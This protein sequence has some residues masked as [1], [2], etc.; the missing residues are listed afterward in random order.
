VANFWEI[1][2][3][4]GDDPG[5]GTDGAWLDRRKNWRNHFPAVPEPG[6]KCRLMGHWQELS[7]FERIGGQN[8]QQVFW[9]TL[10]DQ[11]KVGAH[12]LRAGE[13]LCAIALIKRLFPRL[14]NIEAVIGWRPGGKD[15]NVVHWPSTSYVAALPWLKELADEKHATARASYA[16]AASNNLEAGHMGETETRLYGFPDGSLFDLDGHLLHE[17]GLRAWLGEGLKNEQARGAMLAA[18]KE[19]HKATDTPPAREFYALLLMDGDRIGEQLQR[20]GDT[21][22][23]GLAAFTNRVGDYFSPGNDAMGALVYAGGDDVL[24]MLPVDT[25]IGAAYELRALYGQAFGG[26]AA[27][28]LSGAIVFA[29]YKVPLRRV[30]EAAHHYLDDIAKKRNGR[31]SLALAA[32][33]PGGVSC[34]WVSCWKGDKQEPGQSLVQMARDMRDDPEF[35]AGFFHSLRDR[36]APLFDD[37]DLS[38]EQRGFPAQFG[39]PDLMESLVRA[40]YVRGGIKG[41]DAVAA[42]ERLMD[43]AQPLVR[44]NGNIERSAR[45]SFDAGLMVRFLSQQILSAPQQQHAEDTP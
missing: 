32:L 15:L 45:F 29:H 44:K 26:D 5:D 6:D 42:V 8:A 24:A 4:A 34:E 35:A 16:K 30:M 23:K 3:V 41:A 25:A 33:K 36:Y 21:V 13:R 43:I 40:E 14:D 27:F 10:A 20:D 17:D 11:A 39:D 38:Q 28:T 18:M 1:A 9:E 7:G 37:L 19:L 22:K 2:W 31:D 12:D